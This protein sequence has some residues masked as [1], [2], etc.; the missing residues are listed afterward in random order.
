MGGVKSTASHR[1]VLFDLRNLFKEMG[2][3]TGLL[4][5]L[6]REKDRLLKVINNPALTDN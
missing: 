4:T 2:K 5:T 6:P 3:G 1:D